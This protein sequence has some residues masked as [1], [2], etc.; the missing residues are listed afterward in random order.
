[1]AVTQPLA[2]QRRWRAARWVG[3]A[4]GVGFACSAIFAGFLQWPRAWFLAPHVLATAVLFTAFVRSERVLLRNLWT[5]RW[6][7][8]LA[9]AIL[10]G[11]FGVASVLRQ[12]AGPHPEGASLVLGVLWP[13]AVYGAMDALLLTV[14][15]VLAVQ[16]ASAPGRL[17]LTAQTLGLAASLAVTAAYHAGFPEF[18]GGALLSPLLGNG[19]FTLAYLLTRSP[20]TPTLGH[21]AMHVAA[22]LHGMGSTIQL[23]PHY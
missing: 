18:R 16:S 13:G 10:A 7:Q 15:P 6:R 4:C 9:G 5:E 2:S 23:P 17:A 22:V 21:M 3:L 8:G 20:L 1:M 11:A 19:V 12:P 14:V